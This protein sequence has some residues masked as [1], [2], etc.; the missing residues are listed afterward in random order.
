MQKNWY[1][2]LAEDKEN[3]KRE[4]SKNRYQCM[5]NEEK[6]KLKEY[7]KKII[8]KIIEKKEKGHK[9]ILIEMQS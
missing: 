9:V 8:K 5:S 4:Y 1:N 7:Q 2:N 3:I 6:L